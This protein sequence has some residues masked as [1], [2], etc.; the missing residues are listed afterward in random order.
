MPS[1]EE[2]EAISK[3]RTGYNFHDLHKWMDDP[4]KD[5]GMN[6]RR[7]RHTLDDVYLNFVK[8]KWGD[9][10]VV[11]YIHH[12]VVDYQDTE[13]KWMQKVLKEHVEGFFK[14]KYPNNQ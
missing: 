9:L 3:K 4:Q 13:D 7:E 12:I 6:H 11:E 10:G 14:K 2:H 5:L 8:E 1:V